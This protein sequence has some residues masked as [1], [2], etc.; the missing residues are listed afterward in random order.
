MS[1]VERTSVF[2]AERKEVF[3]RIQR[4][5]TLQHIARPYATFTPVV[6]EAGRT[7]MPGSTSSYHLRLFGV[8]PFGTHTIHVVRFD[9]D[10]IQSHEG[11]GRVPVWNHTIRMEELPG[12]RTRYTDHVEIE[13]G[14][15][16]PFV[17]IWANAFYAHRQRRWQK[18]LKGSRQPM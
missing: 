17:W 4:L 18:L 5:E 12:G 13:A 6:P 14:W 2:P 15:K 7:W 1:V 3:R 16:T 10:L 8:I 9:E 11:S